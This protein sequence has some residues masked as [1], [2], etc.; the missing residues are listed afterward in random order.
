MIPLKLTLRN[1]MCYREDVPP[2]DFRGIHLVCLAGGNG[3]G[4]SALLDAMTW[5]LWGKARARHDDELIH[6]GQSEMEVE[7]EFALGDNRYRVIRKRDSKGRGRSALE[8]QILDNDRY[9]SITESTLRATQARIVDTLRMDYDTF[10]NSAFLLQGRADEFTIKTPAERKR[11]LGEILGLGIYDQFEERARDRARAKDVER[12]EIEAS[13]HEIERELERRPEYEIQLQAAEKAVEELGAALAVEEARLK[14]LS[15]ER[16]SLSLKMTQATDLEQ[17][18]ARAEREAQELQ[19]EIDDREK[20]LQGFESIL[21]RASAIEEG[22]AL[23]QT[24]QAEDAEFNRKL[25]RLMALGERQRGLESAIAEARHQL[26]V[27]RR[28]CQQRLADLEEKAQGAE[29]LA[30][31]LAQVQASLARLADLEAEREERLSAIQAFSMEV[32]TL[33]SSNEALRAEMESLKEKLDLLAGAEAKCPLC[34]QDLSEDEASRI[35]ADYQ[36]QGQERGDLYRDNRQRLGDL[37]AEIRSLEEAIRGV[38]VELRAKPALQKREATLERALV[39]AEKAR[40]DL[41][42]QQVVLAA[43]DRQLEQ[44]EYAVEEQAH[45]AELRE[46]ATALG[47]NAEVHEA[48]RQRLREYA[49]FEGDRRELETARQLREG[50]RRNLERARE[51]LSRRHESLAADGE[52]LEALRLETARWPEVVQE[53]EAKQMHVDELRRNINRARLELGAAQQR[54]DTCR[55]L[56]GEKERKTALAQRAAQEQAIYEELRL[57]FGKKGIQAMIIEGV[58]PE[59]EDEANVLLSRMTDG[60]MYVSFETQREARTTDATIETLDIIIRDEL[61]PRSYQL[62]SG[63][64]SFRVNF[65]IRVAL[66]KLLA[67]RAGARLQTLVIDEG[68]GSQDAQGRERLVEAINTIQDD[69]EKILVITHIEELRDMFPV[70]IDVFKTPAGSQIMVN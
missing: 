17:R 19:V 40:Q 63:G 59:I 44:G 53:L 5:A 20:R 37:S 30:E 55:Q 22:Y 65:A 46:Q 41:T 4:K 51:S 2:L 58:I 12:R 52:R 24:A 64:E 16:Q 38:E 15:E 45:L 18:I 49:S 31:E 3:H 61:G 48:A 43:L 32:V 8:F 1:F 36:T 66:S 60:R 7:F 28:L 13:L 33:Q 62:F 27:E 25:S 68:F 9:R 42:G 34:G 67:R 39:E 56:E 26:E 50:E 10:I 69:F 29:A 6:M 47:Y 11:V 23:L 54:L 14:S 57:A 70:R 35:R 21:G